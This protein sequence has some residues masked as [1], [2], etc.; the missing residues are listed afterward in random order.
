[1]TKKKPAKKPQ[2]SPE[3]KA[4]CKDIVDEL[5]REI[6]E[7]H[8]RQLEE[9]AETLEAAVI[10]LK[11]VEGH[12]GRLGDEI[13]DIRQRVHVTEKCFWRKWW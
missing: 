5:Y 8:S 1:M 12:A 2:V 11:A 7:L 6:E 10:R 3:I 4:A 13:E 9:L